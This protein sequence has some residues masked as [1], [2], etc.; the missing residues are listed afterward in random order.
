MNY[1]WI[2]NLGTIIQKL[3]FK[4][5]IVFSVLFIFNTYTYDYMAD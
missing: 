4:I 5:P 3:D 2:V 1:N